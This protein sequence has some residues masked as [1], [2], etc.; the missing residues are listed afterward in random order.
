[1]LTARWLGLPPEA[2]RLF[3]LAP[4]TIGI[5]GYEREQRVIIRWN[6]RCRLALPS[7][8]WAEQDDLDVRVG[9]PGVEAVTIGLGPDAAKPEINRLRARQSAAYK[10]RALKPPRTS[11]SVDADLAV[12]EATVRRLG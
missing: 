7:Y 11:V 1:V 6:D 4:A 10:A 9:D 2:G 3:A 5:L 8:I 12:F